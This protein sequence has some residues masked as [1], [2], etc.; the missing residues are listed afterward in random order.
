[1]RGSPNQDLVDSTAA[2]R[3]AAL[4]SFW[5]DDDAFFPP[6]G[7]AVWWEVWLRGGPAAQ[8]IDETFS[9]H[10]AAL[11]IKVNAARLTF[12]EIG[13]AHV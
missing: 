13:R 7:T 4:G 5:T 11:G 3:R 12:P 9:G 1:M 10:A 8:A 2:I 6:P